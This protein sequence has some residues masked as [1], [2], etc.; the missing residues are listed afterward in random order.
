[1]RGRIFIGILLIALGLGFLLDRLGII[2]F[3]TLIS[4]YWPAILILVGASQLFSKG[5]S[6]ISGIILIFLGSFFLLK[7][8]EL[9]PEDIGKYFWPALLIIIGI[10][11]IFGRSRHSGMPVSGEDAVN[12]FV[13]FSGL[14]NKC[15]SQDFKGGSATAI[16][17][18]ID[19]DLRDANLREEGAFLD[20]TAVFGG[21][22]LRVPDRWKVIATG[23]PLFGGWENKTRTPSDMPQD[24]PN[25]KIRCFALFGGMEIKN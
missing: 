16:F 6:E 11:I 15:I 13:V 17:G 2:L 9:L 24:Q 10:I 5:H 23:T 20:L 22:S 25:L 1:M 19:L 14:E 3:S 12:H 18:S 21:I 8:L 7:K 4:T